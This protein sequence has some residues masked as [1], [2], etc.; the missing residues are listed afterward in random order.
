[1]NFGEVIRRA[2]HNHLFAR[3][4]APVSKNDPINRLSGD[5]FAIR[6]GEQARIGPIEQI[7]GTTHTDRGDC[8]APAWRQQRSHRFIHCRADWRNG[9]RITTDVSPP[10]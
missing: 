2:A 10:S 7:G 1:M 4:G 3:R 6:R 5:G 8:P 9:V